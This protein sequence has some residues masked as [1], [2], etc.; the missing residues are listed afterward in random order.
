MSGGLKFICQ[1]MLH[2]NYIIIVIC[3]QISNSIIILHLN[4]STIINAT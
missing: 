4:V 2:Y 1:I 3:I